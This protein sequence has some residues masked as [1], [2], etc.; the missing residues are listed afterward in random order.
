MDEEA[1]NSPNAEEEGIPIYS[2]V[3]MP[4][5]LEDVGNHLFDSQ[6]NFGRMSEFKNYSVV[7]TTVELEDA[8]FV[9]GSSKLPF[10]VV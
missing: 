10:S 4:N 8:S 1:E 6:I 2:R 9:S 7:S 5:N 3:D